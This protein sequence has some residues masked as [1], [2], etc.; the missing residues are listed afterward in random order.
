MTDA[1][2]PDP[3]LGV[4]LVYIDGSMRAITALI[5]VGIEDDM[6]LWEAVDPDPDMMVKEL[7]VDRMPPYTTVTVRR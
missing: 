6:H 5:Y 7:Q 4:R 1:R 3:P 2:E